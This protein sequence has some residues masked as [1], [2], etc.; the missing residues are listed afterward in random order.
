V[1]I[2]VVGAGFAGAIMAR[3]LHDSGHA[4]RVVD[5]RDHI[6]GN[7]YD[8]PNE[9]GVLYHRYGPHIFNANDVRIVE[10]LSRFT[11][12]RAYE[13]RVLALTRNGL[14]PVPVNRT[15][16]SL[17]TGLP[18]KT[19]QETAELLE[20]L[21]IPNDDP[22]N[23]EEQV[24]SEV[25]LLIYEELFRDYTEKQWGRPGRSLDRSVV[26]RLR[27][28][29][30]DD[31][32]YSLNRFQAMPSDG[33]TAMFRRLLD[34]I[35]VTL[36]TDARELNV[37]DFDHVVW[38]GPIDEAFGF[39]FGKLPWRSLEFEHQ[40]YESTELY[41]PVGTVNYPSAKFA[42][43]RVTEWR[44]LTG[45]DA[46]WTTLTSEYPLGIGDPYYPV[47]AADAHAMYE[48]YDRLAKR[49]TKMTFVGRLARYQYLSM[50]QVVGQAL[51]AARTLTAS[52][53]PS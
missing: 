11:D 14:V 48:R 32:R 40:H 44:H 20:D 22:Q 25:G 12:W 2:L 39:C 1:V 6:A 36:N 52:L 23:V 46:D 3:Q 49:A 21:R 15:T 47:P 33:Y 41:Q 10:F 43:T 31:D 27:A 24:L 53:S 4:V 50:H 19:E 7:A 51:K 37:D 17:L 30:T 16:V 26:G 28:R 29:L 9:H 35:D 5:R 8:E 13:H 18:L 34:G 42:F 45:Q 38:T